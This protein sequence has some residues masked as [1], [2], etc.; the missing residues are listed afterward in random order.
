MVRWHACAVGMGTTTQPPEGGDSREW[1]L[2][3][4]RAEYAEM[5]GLSLTPAQAQRLFGA[6]RDDCDWALNE[7]TERGVLR[8]THAGAYVRA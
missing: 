2:R 8:R 3:R 5:P 1:L 7:L 6:A 4:L